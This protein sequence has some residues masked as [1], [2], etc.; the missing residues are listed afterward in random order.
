MLFGRSGAWQ[1]DA[2]GERRGNEQSGR[3]RAA[4]LRTAVVSTASSARREVKRRP[5]DPCGAQPANW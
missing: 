4:E 1:N 5:H 2:D 3:H